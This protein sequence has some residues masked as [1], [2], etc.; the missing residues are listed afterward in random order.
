MKWT[1][2][3]N[4]IMMRDELAVAFGPDNKIYAVGGYGGPEKYIN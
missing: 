1:R 4:M 2:L 3:P